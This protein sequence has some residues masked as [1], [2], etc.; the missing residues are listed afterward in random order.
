M[1]FKDKFPSLQQYRFFP[2]LV[3]DPDEVEID[4]E[5]DPAGHSVNINWIERNCRDNQK[6]KEAIDE[7]FDADDEEEKVYRAILYKKLRLG[8]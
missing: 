6:I 3:G 4:I 5:Y 8:E 1:S 7:V 2:C